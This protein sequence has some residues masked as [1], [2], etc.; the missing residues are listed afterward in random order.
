MHTSTASRSLSLSIAF[1]QHYNNN[2]ERNTTSEKS[3][4][5]STRAHKSLFFLDSALLTVDS[6]SPSCS[7]GR[8]A[9]VMEVR[10]FYLLQRNVSSQRSDYHPTTLSLIT[11]MSTITPITPI[12][13]RYRQTFREVFEYRVFHLR[14]QRF[15]GFR[16]LISWNKPK[17]TLVT[18]E[19]AKI[20]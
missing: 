15:I 16:K 11:P 14:D 10:C 9:P 12:N 6:P 1:L 18:S 2:I 5:M 19:Q 3:Y 20:D 7:E 17:S 4:Y 8:I 13:Y